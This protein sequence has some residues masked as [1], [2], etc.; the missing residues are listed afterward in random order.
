MRPEL[1]AA[2]TGGV[3]KRASSSN[4]QGK[5]LYPAPRSGPPSWKPP[6]GPRRTCGPCAPSCMTPLPEGELLEVTPE[7]VDLTGGCLVFRTLKKRRQGLYRAVP[8]PRPP[9]DDVDPRAPR[10]EDPE[11][12]RRVR[13][14]CTT[15]PLPTQACA[16]T[17]TGRR[18]LP[19]HAGQR[20]IDARSRL[21]R[22]DRSA[23]STTARGPTRR[24]TDGMR[25]NSQEGGIG[26]RLCQASDLAYG[27][28]P[29][30]DT[31]GGVGRYSQAGAGRAHGEASYR[32]SLRYLARSETT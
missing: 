3:P 30:A 1:P 21:L 2:P 32:S 15:L 26:F 27:F 28:Y 4:R 14:S 18:R 7:H 13:R 12:R 31:T 16:C 8:V 9:F 24:I 10:Q 19:Q 5:R 11:Q 17:A 29:E 20:A 23:R 25:W 22:S 6:V